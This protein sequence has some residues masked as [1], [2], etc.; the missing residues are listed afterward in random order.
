MRKSKRDQQEIALRLGENIIRVRE[1]RDDVDAL[2]ERTEWLE[3]TKEQ[4]WKVQ[5][6]DTGTLPS[7]PPLRDFIPKVGW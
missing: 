5:V 1:L 7:L 2:I 4:S 3:T 6:T